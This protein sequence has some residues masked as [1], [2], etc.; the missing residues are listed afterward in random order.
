MKPRRDLMILVAAVGVSAGGDIGA[1]AALAVHVQESTHSGLAVAGLF[2]AN[3]LALAVAAPA[4]GAI[5]DRADARGL[6]IAASAFQAVVAAALA[7]TPGL[8]G[9]L[10][11]CVLLGL[12]GA[13]AV[14]AEFALVGAVAA[15]GAGAKRANARVETARNLGYLLGPLAGAGLV[16]LWSVGAAL[17]FDAAT[18][19]AIGLGAAMLTTRRP[20]SAAPGRE[21]PRARDGIGLLTRDPVLRIT[22]AVLVGSLLAMSMSISADAFFV[23]Q[24]LHTGPIGL[25]LLLSS[26]MVGM[27][28][29]SLVCAKRFSVGALAAAALL[30]TVVQGTG[31]L[32]AAAIAVLPVALVLYAVGG[33]G[34]GVKNVAARALIHDR[35]QAAAHGR[36]F[37]TYAALRNC[38]ELAAL[39]IGGVLVDTIGARGTL[40]LAGAATA[41]IGLL[42]CAGLGQNRAPA[43]AGRPGRSL[44]RAIFA[45]P[46]SPMSLRRFPGL[47]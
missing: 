6:L 8:P 9:V 28:L 7:S 24:W 22:T 19:V 25:G 44:L 42:G 3:W 29:G 13:I 45:N 12:G 34:H 40:L 39:V 17:A 38:A 1:I 31:K 47:K 15:Q 18:F 36:A 43:T 30:G 11:L 14:P 23:R 26:W 4:G 46:R 16:A 37:A 5:V 2:L 21:R 20:G 32:G 41:V 33:A 35:V 10:A 27:V